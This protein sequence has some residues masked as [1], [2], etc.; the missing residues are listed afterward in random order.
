MSSLSFGTTYRSLD[1]KCTV[2]VN[3]KPDFRNC[4]S[5]CWFLKKLQD[6]KSLFLLTKRRR[7][8]ILILWEEYLQ[9]EALFLTQNVHTL[10]VILGMQLS[11]NTF[12]GLSIGTVPNSTI[13]LDPPIQRTNLLK[14]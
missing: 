14:R 1:D 10:P 13:L 8:L 3:L 7:P 12:Y 6:N 2:I 9:T 4:L 5:K 11:V